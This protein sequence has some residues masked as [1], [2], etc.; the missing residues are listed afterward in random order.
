M[1]YL[2]ANRLFE[3]V[4]KQSRILVERSNQTYGI[5]HDIVKTLS[6]DK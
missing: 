6:R 1:F 5:V 4:A 2:F 3:D